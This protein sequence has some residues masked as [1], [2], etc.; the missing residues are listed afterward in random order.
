MRQS[1]YII[2]SRVALRAGNTLLTSLFFFKEFLSL[3]MSI[4][5]RKQNCSLWIPCSVSK[6]CPVKHLRCY[7]PAT[8]SYLV[9]WYR[10]VNPMAC[11][12]RIV[13][14]TD[15][16]VVSSLF[17]VLYTSPLMWTHSLGVSCSQLQDWSPPHPW[18]SCLLQIQLLKDGLWYFS[19]PLLWK[20]VIRRVL[21]PQ[22]KSVW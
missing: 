11:W 14:Q 7:D 21:V 5:G 15:S 22:L 13:S 3:F 10:P 6:G 9:C 2:P 4:Y 8:S 16:R 18:L 1:P 20:W 12:R 19:F 17:A